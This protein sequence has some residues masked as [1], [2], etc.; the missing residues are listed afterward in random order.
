MDTPVVAVG[1][2][3]ALCFSTGEEEQKYVNLRANP[4]VVLT[5]GC[6]SWDHGLDVVVEC[7][8]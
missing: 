6:N 3:G 8:P 7:S 5:T 4:H 1:T 2:G